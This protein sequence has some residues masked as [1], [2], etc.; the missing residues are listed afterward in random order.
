MGACIGTWLSASTHEPSQ[1][2]MP[3]IEIIPSARRLMKSLRDMGYDFAQAIADVVDNSIAARST[4]IRIDV[5]F[6]GDESWVR[7]ADDGLGMRAE[8]LRE[9]MRYGAERDYD[10]EDL[11]KF[12]LGLKTASMSQC[13]RL[14]VASRWNPKRAEVHAYAWDLEHIEGTN[15]WEILPLTRQEHGPALHDVLKDRPGTVVLWQRLDRILGYRHPYGES[16]KNRLAQMAREAEQHLSMVLHRFLSGD[17][18]RRIHIHVNDNEVRPWDPFCRSEPRTSK[19]EPLYVRVEEEGAKGAVRIEPYILPHQ[20]DFSS[21]SAFK[22]AA[23][24]N[25]WNQQQGL[26]VYRAG[27]LIQSGGW[28]RLRAPDEHT[29]LAR[30]AVSFAPSLD[31]AFK[32]NVAKMR[33]QIPS[34]I[35][36]ELASLIQQLTREARRVYDR[37]EKK[38]PASD[39]GSS[40]VSKGSG[41]GGGSDAG[42]IGASSKPGDA[43]SRPMSD[44]DR[45]LNLD[46]WTA[47]TLSAA[48]TR[49][50]PVVKAVLE[51][52]ETH[53]TRRVG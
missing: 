3:G 37:K 10:D 26:Y 1:K 17:A 47:L 42:V 46:E 11:G 33:V 32:V 50:K 8:E 35:R 41:R 24:P 31:E 49:E 20:S 5:E 48:T 28:S 4:R 25:G 16:A 38:N 43:R 19:W 53:N 27:R 21:P 18:K 12:G 9:A 36:D 14:S 30:V 13:R 15:K 45:K 39:G 34:S 52:L 2:I 51:R 7:I 44:V 40:T 22:N 29:K 6:D 23:G